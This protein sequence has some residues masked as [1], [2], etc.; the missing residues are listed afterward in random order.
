MAVDMFLKLDGI[1]G[2]SPD[3]A[4]KEE[5]QIQSFSFGVHQTGSS[6]DGGGGGAGKASFEDIHITK[7][8]DIATPPLMEACA[9]GKH[10]KNAVLT[11]RKAGGKQEEYYKIKL[12]DLLVSS[13]QNTGHGNEAP[14]EQLSMNFAKIEFEYYPQKAD[15][16]LGGVS[17][18][19]YDI[20]QNV[21]V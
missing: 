20:K 6:A 4:H 1:K 16:T 17:K 14:M 5:I 12:T 19:G 8:A 7:A 3:K 2:E 15:G 10:I 18:A 11:V 21:K 9:T 13:L